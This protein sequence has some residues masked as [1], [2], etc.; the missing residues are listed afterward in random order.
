MHVGFA[1]S[2]DASGLCPDTVHHQLAVCPCARGEVWRESTSRHNFNLQYR[3]AVSC[4]RAVARHGAPPVRT[5]SLPIIKA[6]D[7]H[8]EVQLRKE[9]QLHA[10]ATHRAVLQVPHTCKFANCNS[11]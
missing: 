10:E 4:E 3:R 9:A 11:E 6:G 8:A 5:C 7:A 2:V 1:H